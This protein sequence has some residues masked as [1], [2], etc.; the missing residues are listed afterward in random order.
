MLSGALFLCFGKRSHMHQVTL[1]GRKE[2]A[3]QED[4][5][6]PRQAGRQEAG[7]LAGRSQRRV[8]TQDDLHL[9][10]VQ[11]PPVGESHDALFVVH[12]AG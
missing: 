1:R 12:Q 7:R 9:C 2:E 11:F 6:V 10:A 4:S 8:A 5:R 3:V